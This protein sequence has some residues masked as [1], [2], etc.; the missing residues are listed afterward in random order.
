MSI[1]MNDCTKPTFIG[2]PP[3]RLNHIG[4]IVVTS[5]I[6]N[7]VNM[8]IGKTE[9]YLQVGNETQAHRLYDFG[10]DVVFRLDPD[11]VYPPFPA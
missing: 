8:F 10:K 7:A 6:Q 4:P 3:R 9:F 1:V 11:F 2:Q 5:S